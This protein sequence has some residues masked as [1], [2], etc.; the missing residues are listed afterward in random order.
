[1]ARQSV[2]EQY[3]RRLAHRDRVEQVQLQPKQIVESKR[4]RKNY[5][6]VRHNLDRIR[7]DRRGGSPALSFPTQGLPSI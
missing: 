2:Q 7:E 6:E 3:R 4:R 5:V 1:M